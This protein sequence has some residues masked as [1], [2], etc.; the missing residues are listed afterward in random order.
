MNSQ[1]HEGKSYIATNS[2]YHEGKS[3]IATNI[4]YHEGKSYI[5]TNSQY[6]EGKSYIATNSQ[7]HEGKSYIA[8]NSQYHEGKSYIAQ[9][10]KGAKNR[11]NTGH[12]H[13]INPKI[14]RTYHRNLPFHSVPNYVHDSN[15]ISDFIPVYVHSVQYTDFVHS[16]ALSDSEHSENS[17]HSENMAQPPTPPGPHEAIKTKSYESKRAKCL[18]KDPYQNKDSLILGQVKANISTSHQFRMER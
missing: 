1:Y 14:D 13:P 18:I 10:L 3:Y 7:Y 5:A 11:G 6:H 15:S 16:V 4:Q 12:L 17:V 8:T 9:P 2:Q